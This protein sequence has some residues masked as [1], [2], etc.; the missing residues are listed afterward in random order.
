MYSPHN[1]SASIVSSE[2]EWRAAG[3]MTGK[4]V[5]VI[6]EVTS[7][8]ESM[9]QVKPQKKKVRPKKQFMED[10][11]H[12][13]GRGK[14]KPPISRVTA[15]SAVSPQAASKKGRAPKVSKNNFV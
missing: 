1:I 14:S 9:Q 10:P 3:P 12:S 7:G 6:D 13:I 11:R 15:E 8:V 2:H 4:H 5:A